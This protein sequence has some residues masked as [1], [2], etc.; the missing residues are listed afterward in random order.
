[1][2]EPDYASPDFVERERQGI[3]E[4]FRGFPFFK[5]M[6]F[7]LLEIEPGRSRLAMNWR[8]ELNQ[9]AGILHGGANAALVDTSIAQAIVLTSNFQAAKAAGGGMVSVDLRIRYLRPV[10]GGR[11]F[12]EARV[13]RPGRQIVHASATITDEAGKDVAFGE[14]IYMLIGAEQLHK[15][16]AKP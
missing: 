4:F 16:E 3:R 12:C 6:G 10:S 13:T 15:R 7:E 8:S 14:S 2:S 11:I 9:P 5:L 1:M